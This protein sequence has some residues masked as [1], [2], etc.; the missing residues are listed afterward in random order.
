MH[1]CRA[2]ENFKDDD[3][4]DGDEADSVEVFFEL[5]LSPSATSSKAKTCNL[6]FRYVAK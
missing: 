5:L 6:S 2:D 1:V 3:D 4:G